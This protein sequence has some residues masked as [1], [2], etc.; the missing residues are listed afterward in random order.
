[1]PA[2]A[3]QTHEKFCQLVA[4]GRTKKQ[5]FLEARDP[6][7]PPLGS[8]GSIRQSATNLM[9]RADV[10]AR[11]AELTERMFDAKIEATQDIVRK[12]ALTREWVVDALRENVE[13][14]M[15]AVAV[16]DSNGKPTGE[17]KYDGSVAN[18]AL[19]LL[20]KE[21]GMFVDRTENTNVNYAVSDQPPTPEE[22][23]KEYT[24]H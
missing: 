22:W 12:E 3:N 4:S 7:K 20:G 13:R 1:M 2:L 6:S 18:R 11:I 14:A 16:L 15:Q 19:E 8:D 17:Y 24:T 10:R 5:A 23:A 21:I 9:N